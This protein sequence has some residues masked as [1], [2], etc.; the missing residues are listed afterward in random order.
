[1]LLVQCE[2]VPV[3][4]ALLFEEVVLPPMTPP[5]L[6]TV[7]PP[8][9]SSWLPALA[10]PTRKLLVVVSI[11]PTPVTVTVPASAKLLLAVRASVPPLTVVPPVYVLAALRIKV[12]APLLTSVPL[13]LITPERVNAAAEL[14]TPMPPLPEARLMPRFIEVFVV[15]A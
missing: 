9:T 5:E 7:P 1:M 8:L 11:E 6:A 2:F 13:L 3:T 10:L 12:P 14:E 15:P 4:S